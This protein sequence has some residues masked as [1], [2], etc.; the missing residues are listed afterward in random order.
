MKTVATITK[1]VTLNETHTMTNIMI[2][3]SLKKALSHFEALKKDFSHYIDG[4]GEF[5]LEK[6][7]LENYYFGSGYDEKNRFVTFSIGVDKVY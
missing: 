3:S 1:E 6:T 4:N 5:I 2:F 7:N